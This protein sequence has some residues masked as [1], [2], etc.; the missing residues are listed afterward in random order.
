MAGKDDKDKAGSR[1]DSPFLKGNPFA[2]KPLFPPK[3][4]SG[5]PRPAEP[6]KAEAVREGPECPVART[7]WKAPEQPRLATGQDALD[8]LNPR[9]LP[10]AP[11]LAQPQC[12]ARLEIGPGGREAKGKPRYMRS[13]AVFVVGALMVYQHARNNVPPALVGRL[14]P[15]AF[16]SAARRG[17]R[18]C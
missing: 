17:R 6:P 10:Q 3:L 9:R 13:L 5:T 18:R 14:P 1:P 2:G 11:Y 7:S 12:A 15:D 8:R 4:D 16:L